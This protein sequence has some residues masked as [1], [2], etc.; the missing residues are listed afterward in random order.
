[1]PLFELETL[2]KRFLKEKHKIKN[3]AQE[4]APEEK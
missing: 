2:Y 4:E 1:M 3:C